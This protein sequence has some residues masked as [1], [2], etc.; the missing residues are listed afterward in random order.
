MK[1]LLAIVDAEF[2]SLMITLNILRHSTRIQN[3]NFTFD[4]QL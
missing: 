3:E 2:K 1:L 4:L